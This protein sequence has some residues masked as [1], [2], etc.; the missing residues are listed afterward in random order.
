MLSGHREQIANGLDEADKQRSSKCQLSDSPNFACSLL[1]SNQP[2][3]DCF[4]GPQH[5]SHPIP[6]L[7]FDPQGNRDR[8]MTSRAMSD[9]QQIASVQVFEAIEV[10]EVALATPLHSCQQRTRMPFAGTSTL[11]QL[12]AVERT[13]ADRRWATIASPFEGGTCQCSSLEPRRS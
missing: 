4:V 12:W 13:E 10:E 1:P 8:T 6:S 7:Q 5:S 3:I 2:P 11:S 9:A